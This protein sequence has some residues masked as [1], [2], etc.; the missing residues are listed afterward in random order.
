M[1]KLIIW[2]SRFPNER[3]ILTIKEDFCMLD[4][5]TGGGG[6]APVCFYM[7]PPLLK[8]NQKAFFKKKSKSDVKKN[9]KAGIVLPKA[10]K[11]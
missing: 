4:F 6:F 3:I 1:L 8:K 10:G 5:L 9:Q 11:R 7:V 2:F